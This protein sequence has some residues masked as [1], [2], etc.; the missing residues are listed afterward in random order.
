MASPP[1]F[2]CKELRSK[3][4]ALPGR[5]PR[6]PAECDDSNHCWCHHT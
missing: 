1:T 2:F 4:L 5:L 6:H 3:K